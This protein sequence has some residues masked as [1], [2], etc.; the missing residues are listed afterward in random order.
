MSRKFK[1][2]DADKLYFITYSVVYWIDVFTRIEYRDVLIE[3]WNYCQR[4]KGLEIYSWIIMTNHVHLI[5][6]SNKD[7]LE[8]IVR[9]MKRHSSSQI[10]LLL[11]AGKKE[12]RRDWMLMLMK[13][14]GLSNRLN[15][16]WQFWQQ[17]N[18]PLEI[19][20][21]SMFYRAVDYIHHNPVKAGFVENE[22]DWLYSS[23]R[24][25]KGRKGLIQLC[26]LL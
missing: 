24:D 13:K 19:V 22:E 1:F 4:N 26:N 9:D 18:K 23:A 21:D 16:D 7:P 12:S 2:S 20:D 25:F 5:V 6:R 14:A 8:N 17:H 11:M 15:N 3:S 10:K